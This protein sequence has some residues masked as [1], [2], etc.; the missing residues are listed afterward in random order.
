MKAFLFASLDCTTFISQG[1]QPCV[2]ELDMSHNF[3]SNIAR[4]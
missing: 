4:T 3:F 1:R 2:F